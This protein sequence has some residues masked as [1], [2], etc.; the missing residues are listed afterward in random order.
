[1]FADRLLNL[2]IERLKKQGHSAHPYHSELGLITEILPCCVHINSMQDFSFKYISESGKTILDNTDN[3]LI[4]GGLSIL[5]KHQSSYTLSDVLPK[6]IEHINTGKSY[7]YYQDWKTNH[8]ERFIFTTVSK[9]LN[10]T[11]FVSIS[12][13]PQ[14]FNEILNHEIPICSINKCY[15]N[16]KRRI[17]LLTKR[18]K[19]IVCL[20]GKDYCRSRISN[21]CFIS[22]KTTKKHCENIYK[23][24]GTHNRAKLKTISSIL[25][26]C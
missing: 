11:E 6:M 20:L 3:N 13:F 10:N 4:N 23:K 19:E 14:L 17:Q 7:L 18:E 15:R 25:N 24:L 16:Y 12:I 21:L 2:Q 8:G 9:R 1:M 5:E 26:Y 22:E